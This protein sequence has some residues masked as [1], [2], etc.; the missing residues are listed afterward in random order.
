MYNESQFPRHASDVVQATLAP[1]GVIAGWPAMITIPVLVVGFSFLTNVV[2]TPFL[3][4]GIILVAGYF[5]CRFGLPATEGNVMAGWHAR[6]RDGASAVQAVLYF[7]F[8]SLFWVIPVAALSLL[9]AGD[10]LGVLSG[11]QAAVGLSS[12]AAAVTV[13][14]LV[15]APILT[16]IIS[17]RARRMD[18]LL[19]FTVLRGLFR[20]R[21]RD[22]VF[23]FSTFFG[24]LATF[25][26]IYSFPLLVLATFV[27]PGGVPDIVFLAINALPLG[28][29]PVLLGRLTGAYVHS[30]S[31]SAKAGVEH[32]RAPANSGGAT[33]SRSQKTAGPRWNDVLSAAN[34]VGDEKLDSAIKSA[35]IRVGKDPGDLKTTCQ[36]A[37]LIGRTR[38]S[39]EARLF[40]ESAIRRCV[41][42]DAPALAAHLYLHYG[43]RRKELQLDASCK[44]QLVNGLV[45]LQRFPDAA[46]CLHAAVAE[47]EGRP[48]DAQNGL[49]KIAGE[50]AKAGKH[51]EAAVIYD[52]F[53]KQFPKSDMLEDVQAAI[54]KEKQLQQTRYSAARGA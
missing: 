1:S 48:V 34:A 25:W 41:S 40:T 36:L 39:E 31:L 4:V 37:L 11:S 53:L 27:L 29:S 38:R 47:E 32:I 24:G 13:A 51:A 52:F 22:L 14:L 10:P 43:N 8:L 30:G 5:I 28:M 15:L 45:R 54:R 6:Q 33:A 20:F 12:I 18:D 9:A 16:A 50:A 46:W 17:L 23:L 35:R 42:Q 21:L 3:A 19:S 44:R 49:I 2:A 26:L 7:L